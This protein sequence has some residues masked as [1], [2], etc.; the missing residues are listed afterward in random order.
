MAGFSE[1]KRHFPPLDGLRGLAVLSILVAH[2]FFQGGDSR[3]ARLLT[4]LTSGAW[5][6]VTLF[7]VFF[8]LLDLRHSHRR[9]GEAELVRQLFR[10]RSLR[11]FPLYFMFLVCYQF[12][13][14]FWNWAAEQ[15]PEVD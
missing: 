8:R 2:S 11:I 1:D 9:E 6:G 7:F 3:L 4:A 12:V 10:R 13:L 14:P 5:V 15:L